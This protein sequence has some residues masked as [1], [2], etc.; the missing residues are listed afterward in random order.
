M[1]T[2]M[3]SL[4]IA[5]ES[6][7]AHLAQKR[8]T[9]TS[10]TFLSALHGA[11]HIP[12][13]GNFDYHGE[14][15]ARLGASEVDEH[16]QT[17]VPQ[18]NGMSATHSTQLVVLLNSNVNAFR[19]ALGS[20][21]PA[22]ATLLKLKLKP[23]RTPVQCKPRLQPLKHR[24][25]LTDHVKQLLAYQLVFRNISA[26]WVA[27]ALPFLK[28]RTSQL[29]TGRRPAPCQQA[30]RSIPV[31][32]ALTFWSFFIEQTRALALCG[33][34]ATNSG[35]FIVSCWKIL[36]QQMSSLVFRAKM[37]LAQ[38]PVGTS[39]DFYHVLHRSSWYWKRTNLCHQTRESLL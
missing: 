19:S 4:G 39:R 6:Q 8:G 11:E 18:A 16:L 29:P 1:T 31:A 36:V 2:L 25:F 10:S 34:L 35:K 24:Q 27:V 23:G 38:S 20:N 12:E 9:T 3:A 15:P 22:G 5:V 14:G 26:E 17:A 33:G 30:L 28:P 13:K 32:N 37:I 21:P 7:A